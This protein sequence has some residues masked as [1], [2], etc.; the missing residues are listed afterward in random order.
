MQVLE[1]LKTHFQAYVWTHVLSILIGLMLLKQVKTLTALQGDESVPTLSRT[2]NVYEWPLEELRAA[3]RALITQALHKHHRRRRGRQPIVYLILDDTVLPKRGKKLPYLGFHFSPSQDRVVQGWDL[4][5]AAL[6]VGSF[7]APWDWRCYVNERFLEEDFQ[8]RTEMAAELIH[9]FE[10]PPASRVIVLVDSTY[11]CSPVI[12]AA[13]KRGFSVV[14][15]VKKNR[16]LSDG[17]RAWDVPE[18]TVAY[19]QG[20]EIPVKVLHRGW[21]KGRRTVIS[22]DL[23]LGRRQIL[24]HLKRRWGI[25]V[26]FKMLKEHFGLGDSRCRGKR[27]LERWVELVLLAYVLAGLTR[28]GKQLLG[29]KPSWGEV[30]QE[31][32]WSLIQTATEV[33]GCLAALERLILWSFQFLF[34]VSIPKAQQEAILTS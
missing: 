12:L 9:S 31:W 6:R 2:M 27:S 13:H 25:E 32:G 18:E 14:G 5:F 4:V 30:R 29:R 28:W 23:S 3:R 8:K 33:R 19:L 20:L 16:L 26:M 11:C 10:P 22:T 17:R 24:R 15:W 1:Q 34:P 7:T 21:G